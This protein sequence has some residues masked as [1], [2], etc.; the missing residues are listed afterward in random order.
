MEKFLDKIA[1]IDPVLGPLLALS[2]LV[3]W[4][5]AKGYI[6]LVKDVIVLL[7]TVDDGF[8]SLGSQRLEDVRHRTQ[9]ESDL[10]EIKRRIE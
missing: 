9:I 6:N 4:L 2:F 10:Q 1:A 3:N 8:A 5:V 7:R